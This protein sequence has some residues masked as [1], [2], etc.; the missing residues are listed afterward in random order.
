MLGGLIAT[1]MSL[2]L[3]PSVNR[4]RKYIF[5]IHIM[6]TDKIFWIEEIMKYYVHSIS[7]GLN[8]M[9]LL[10]KLLGIFLL[11]FTELFKSIILCP[12]FTGYEVKQHP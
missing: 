8:R 6:G 4:V 10:L 9:P 1:G 12:H 2:L 5:L 3:D 7:V 11:K